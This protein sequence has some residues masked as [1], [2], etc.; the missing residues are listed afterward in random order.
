[1]RYLRKPALSRARRV[2]ALAG[3]ASLAAGTLLLLAPG[4][5]SEAATTRAAGTVPSPVTV[6]GP[7]LWDP[8]TSKPF[9]T[10]STVTVSQT[11]DLVDQMVHVSWTGFTPSSQPQYDAQA[12]RY[13]VMVAECKGT[14]PTKWSDCYMAGQG[15]QPDIQGPFGPSNEAYVT[16]SG[17]GTGQ[18]DIAIESKTVN[19]MLDCS[20]ASPCSLAIVPGQGGNSLSSPPKCTSHSSDSTLAIPDYTFSSAYGACSWDDRIIVPMQFSTAATGCKLANPAFTADGSPPLARAMQ[21]WL[22]G[23]C[24]GKNGL[25][26]LYDAEIGEPQS[27]GDTYAGLADVALTTRPAKADSDV[28]HQ[29]AR[30]QDLCLRAGRDHRGDDRVLDGRPGHRAAVHRREAQ[31][32]A[33][34]QAAHHVVQLLRG[35]LHPQAE[36]RPGT[37]LRQGREQQPRHLV[38]RPRVQEPQPRVQTPAGAGGQFQ[39]PTVQAGNYDLSWTVTRWISA[40]PTASAFIK[41][42]PAPGGMHINTYYKGM[43]YPTDSFLS[44]DPYLLIQHQYSPTYPPEKVALY[45]SENWD[46]GTQWQKDPVTGNY[47]ANSPEAPG[48][49][50]LIS[51]LGDGDSAAYD[52]PVMAIPNAAGQYVTPTSAAMSAAIKHLVSSGNGTQQVDLANTDP[53]MY[54]MTMIVYAMVPTSGVG[55]TKAAA[56]ARFLDYVAGAG[57]NPG[58]APGQLPAGYLPLTASMRAQTQKIATEVARQSRAKPGGGP[59]GNGGTGGNGGGSG[60]GGTPSPTSSQ[61]PSTDHPLG[62]KATKTSVSLPKARPSHG[63]VITM[64]AVA[65][66]L[67]ATLTRFALPVLLILGGLALLAGSSA[68]VVSGESGARLRRV[69]RVPRSAARRTWSGL[70]RRGGRH[71]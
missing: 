67:S 49:R 40:S 4:L 10:A 36:P 54:P 21:Q 13:S 43:T 22:T 17:Q 70:N 8:K 33:A 48:S 32:A 42:T 38:R 47:P 65:H 59:G 35:W 46:P 1:M 53:S 16:T 20:A 18:A 11:K 60:T 7:H 28:D 63:P 9:A 29:P 14:N 58:V 44:Q 50:S 34:H 66:P 27:I 39:V 41:G 30:G 26:I 56:I 69:A 23:L 3:L 55:H 15:A 6:T 61:S 71:P 62:Q 24:G 64:V 19:S 45:Q 2:T 37:G 31:P 57:Q 52:F 5:H 51:V 25:G 68:L 12:S